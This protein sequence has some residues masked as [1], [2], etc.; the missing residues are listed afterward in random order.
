MS[1]KDTAAAISAALGMAMIHQ[2]V[3]AQVM[4]HGK[5]YAA[6]EAMF[7]ASHLSEPLTTYTTGWRDS[8]P[9]E[10]LINFIGPPIEVA[11]RFEFLKAVNGELFVAMDEEE[12]VRAIGADFGEV[13]FSGERVDSS[14][15]NKGLS[16][17]VDHDRVDRRRA[18]WQQ[19]FVDLLMR[20]LKRTDA[21][22]AILAL[23]SATGNA[24]PEVWGTTLPLDD[25]R[26]Y[27][28]AA[29]LTSGME[30]NK[31]LFGRP[32]WTILRNAYQNSDKSG[33]FA[34]VAVTVDDIAQE[35]GAERGYIA[36]QMYQSSN[37]A[38]S[39]LI[40]AEVYLFNSM[41]G[42]SEDDP[43]NVK[44]FVSMTDAG[45]LYAV[46]IQEFPKY[47]VITVE[48]YNRWYAATALG[49]KRLSIT[50]G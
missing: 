42:Q 8:Q 25:L 1:L 46:Y 41:D 48:H 43:S 44:H 2:A 18:G 38:K 12:V 27:Y 5:L 37:A 47:T 40:G 29:A 34:N 24:T 50:A 39:R 32:A 10:E 45:T 35:I 28:D 30:P 26:S 21:R 20:R 15:R 3:E 6:N 14:T 13:K 23:Q 33:G 17:R 22:A 11:R 36:G 9:L 19:K 16:I 49:C 31:I 4:Q 7:S